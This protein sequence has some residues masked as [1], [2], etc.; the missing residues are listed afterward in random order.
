MWG[1]NPAEAQPGDYRP[2]H[3]SIRMRD[4]GAHTRPPS[5]FDPE[6]DYQ[7]DQRKV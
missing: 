3:F 4:A 2:R 5:T 1:D 6:P 7:R